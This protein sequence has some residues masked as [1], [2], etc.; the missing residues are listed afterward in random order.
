M[1]GKSIAMSN[2]VEDLKNCASE[3]IESNRENGVIN[4]LEEHLDEL[5]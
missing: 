3:V 5:L 1:V 2:A 4:Y